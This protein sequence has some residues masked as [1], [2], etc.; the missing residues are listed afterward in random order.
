MADVRIRFVLDTSGIHPEAPARSIRQIAQ[1][2]YNIDRRAKGANAELSRLNAELARAMARAYGA[3]VVFRRFGTA[4]NMAFSRLVSFS[5]TT[6]IRGFY[7]LTATVAGATYGLK[8]LFSEFIRVN[9]EFA[10]LEITLK[11]AFKSM[12]VARQLRKEIQKITVVSPIPFEHLAQVSRGLGV[13]PPTRAAIYEQVRQGTL[14]EETGFYRKANKLMEML[15]TFRP[16][17]T[18]E[19]ALFAVRE[20]LT[21]ELRSMMRRFDIPVMMFA[22][23]SG[24]SIQELKRSPMAMFDAMYKAFSDIISPQAIRQ[25][26]LQPRFLKQNIVEQMVKIPMV[27]TGGA[28]FYNTFLEYWDNFFHDAEEW[29]AR[30][31]PD[32]SKKMSASL[33][34]AFNT[35]VTVAGDVFERGMDWAGFGKM[36]MPGVSAMQR[37]YELI[38]ST[39]DWVSKNLPDIA[40]KAVEFFGKLWELLKALG[41]VLKKFGSIWVNQFIARPI[42]TILGTAL[43]T[44]FPRMIAGIIADAT[45][46]LVSSVTRARALLNVQ[47]ALINAPS[48]ATGATRYSLSVPAIRMPLDLAQRLN[49]GS[50]TRGHGYNVNI[51]PDTSGTPYYVRTGIMSQFI[52]NASQREAGRIFNRDTRALLPVIGQWGKELGKSLLSFGAF[53]V[54]IAAASAALYGLGKVVDW[55]KDY[56]QKKL[57]AEEERRKLLSKEELERQAQQYGHFNEMLR[58]MAEAKFTGPLGVNPGAVESMATAVLP[59]V[60]KLQGFRP[61]APALFAEYNVPDV[62]KWV[63]SEITQTAREWA[64][65]QTQ[66]AAEA[67]KLKDYLQAKKPEAFTSI[68]GA[69]VNTRDRALTIETK[70]NEVLLAR[71]NAIYEYLGQESE[72]V[73]LF[74]AENLAFLDKD[75]A[76]TYRSTKTLLKDL[77][78]SATII[79]VGSEALAK[80]NVDVQSFAKVADTSEFKEMDQYIQ[81]IQKRIDPF[82]YM[83]EEL[84]DYQKTVLQMLK[85]QTELEKFISE[86]KGDSAT[87]KLLLDLT[88][89]AAKLREHIEKL[90]AAVHGF[91]RE[92]LVAELNDVKTAIEKVKSGELL[93]KAGKSLLPQ[94][95]AHSVNAFVREVD[96]MS[97]TMARQVLPDMLSTE[98]YDEFE[99]YVL[100]NTRSY[101]EL[102]SSIMGA[103]NEAV[104]KGYYKPKEGLVEKAQEAFAAVSNVSFKFTREEFDSMGAEERTRAIRSQA[105]T[106]FKRFFEALK[107]FHELVNATGDVTSN[108]ELLAQENL[109]FMREDQAVIAKQRRELR[110]DLGAGYFQ[111]FLKVEPFAYDLSP[112]Q[113]DRKR[114]EALEG[115]Q[116]MSKRAGFALPPIPVESFRSV[117]GPENIQLQMDSVK[118]I[119]NWL[120]E[121]WDAIEMG[122]LAGV[123]VLEP[124]MEQ[125]LVDTQKQILES[126]RRFTRGAVIQ[127]AVQTYVIPM[128]SAAGELPGLSPRYAS[129]R[130][131][132]LQRQISEGQ[133]AAKGLG[134]P[135]FEWTTKTAKLETVGGMRP[136]SNLLAQYKELQANAESAGAGLQ[137]YLSETT[138]LTDAQKQSAQQ[139]IIVYEELAIKARRF[140]DETEGRGA[141]ESFTDGLYKVTDEW[142][143]TAD[144]LME[145][146]QQLAQGL[147]DTLAESFSGFIL[148]AKTAEQALLDFGQAFVEMAVQVLMNKMVQSV[149]GFAFKGLGVMFNEGG[150]VPK[151]ATG[152]VIYGGSG[153]RDDVPAMLTAGEY[154]IRREAVQHYGIDNL[155]RINQK[156][157]P[158][159]QHGGLVSP[160]SHQMAAGGLISQNSVGKVGQGQAPQAVIGMATGGLVP[161]IAIRLTTGGPVSQSHSEVYQTQVSQPVIQMATGGLISQSHPGMIYQTQVSQPVIQMAIGGL[162]VQSDSARVVSVPVSQFQRGGLANPGVLRMA[163]GGVVPQS[164]SDTFNIS[165][166][167]NSE[168]VSAETSNVDTRRKDAQN[169]S[170][171]IKT[172]VMEVIQ[173]QQRV[174]GQLR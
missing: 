49:I 39:L 75:I 43:L 105:S 7:L 148:G 57:L 18:A 26:A 84:I 115:I 13:L 4:V 25:I 36:Q 94:L 98:S 92:I 54:A 123:N 51:N 12:E 22:T 160:E 132:D 59:G 129:R 87:Q 37:S 15:V 97:S 10:G 144:N 119:Q 100:A 11:S 6:A 80:F 91:A 64:E 55:I 124:G 116:Q 172:A 35:I 86:P 32:F 168:G 45:K 70:L 63:D 40:T 134:I 99:R 122:L 164:R 147:S 48:A 159:F 140:I 76:E 141:F 1:E 90:P 113:L 46:M 78:S 155:E 28:G 2:I 118:P 151:L 9:E 139:A 150:A 131:E 27:E 135:S 67:V 34:E 53:S 163:T 72:I 81:G 170:R 120:E 162:A 102:V 154:V 96:L 21:G 93:G 62:L 157:V 88:T 130:I 153:V 111:E 107:V 83:R 152:G 24:K 166:A 126:L 20:A 143:A 167:V 77:E 8:A 47:S 29:A 42:L 56:S 14:S 79:D 125:L 68:T 173:E 17:K 128:A 165:I 50:T 31:L 95:T 161:K 127:E 136:V 133:V 82:G 44:Q 52:P 66:I 171:A 30:Y 58:L 149:L 174:G 16:D 110:E 114:Y 69:I 142:M 103:V 3:S 121:L 89:R 169:L 74:G 108:V 109:T 138:D 112:R 71:Q 101:G 61:E 19:D 145:V 156:Q 60:P 33:T 117:F 104:E 65:T 73:Q 41:G 146:G 5:W 85:T 23:A 106:W 137:K 38:R 158:Q